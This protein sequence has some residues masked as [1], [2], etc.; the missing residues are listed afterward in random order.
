MRL[1]YSL[2][3]LVHAEKYPYPMTSAVIVIIALAPQELTRQRI[4][5]GAGGTVRKTHLR[6]RNMP[7]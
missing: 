1:G 2:R 3:T 6:Q 4:Q 7:L 5:L